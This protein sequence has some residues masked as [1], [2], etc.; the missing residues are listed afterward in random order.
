MAGPEHLGAIAAFST[1]ELP[2]RDRLATWR[3]FYAGRLLKLDWEPI[4][5][6]PFDARVAVRT[7][8]ALAVYSARYSPA[9]TR[10]TR[11]F[12]GQE[13]NVVLFLAGQAYRIVQPGREI[14]LGPGEATLLSSTEETRVTSLQAGRHMGIV[15]PRPA[16]R[17]LS[18]GIDDMRMHASRGEA[19]SSLS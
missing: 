6:L 17:M 18:P 5:D 2:E 13:D 10:L 9:R 1:C 8:P 12:I 3:E 19:R 14:E 16:L 11:Q 4:P 7:L 15:L